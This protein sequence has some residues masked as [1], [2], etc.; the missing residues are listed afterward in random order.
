MSKTVNIHDAKTN[1]SKLLARVA[2]GEEVIISK[3][4][5]P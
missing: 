3:A 5:K 2:D 4:G 1:L